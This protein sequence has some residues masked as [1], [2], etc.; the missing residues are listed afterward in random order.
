MWIAKHGKSYGTEAEHEFRL[1]N[2]LKKDAFIKEHNADTTQNHK[3]AHNKF[4]DWTE[5]EFNK[6]INAHPEFVDEPAEFPILH[7][8]G[9]DGLFKGLYDKIDNAVF[10]D[11][12]TSNE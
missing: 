8:I 9:M 2:W 11:Y 5:T 4:S 7:K 12:Y 10:G 3:V 1:A 6:L